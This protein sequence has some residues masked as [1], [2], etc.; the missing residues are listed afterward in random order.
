MSTATSTGPVEYV[1]VKFPGNHFKGE[2]TPALGELVETE[3]SASS[4]SCSSPRTT[5]ETSLGAPA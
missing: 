2:I 1:V 3:R 4:T 5:K